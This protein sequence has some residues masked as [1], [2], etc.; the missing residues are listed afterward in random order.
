MFC[1]S[2]KYPFT[3]DTRTGATGA[4]VVGDVQ[5]EFKTAIVFVPIPDRK[6]VEETAVDW[7]PTQN[8]EFVTHIGAQ[9]N[10]FLILSDTLL[11]RI[12]NIVLRVDVLSYL[13]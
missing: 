1:Y 5:E 3:E 2:Q 12:S 6:T 8:Q 11:T 4:R 7:D 9:V 10:C 13:I